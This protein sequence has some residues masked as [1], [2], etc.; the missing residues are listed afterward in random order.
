MLSNDPKIITR[1]TAIKLLAPIMDYD[2][3]QELHALKREEEQEANEA[4]MAAEEGG[5]E[6]E[7]AAASPAENPVTWKTALEAG[8]ITLNEY[9]EKALNLGEIPDGDL[10]MPQYHAKYAQTFVSSVAATSE[11]SV[12][13]ATGKQQATEERDQ[14]SHDM[15]KEMHEETKKDKAASRKAMAEGGPIAGSNRP[16]SASSAQSSGKPGSNP[17]RPN[18]APV[19]PSS[20]SSS[21]AKGS[22]S[23]SE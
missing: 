6:S 23:K 7:E 22:K 16:G 20:G 8:I 3:M 21:P 19:K 13:I 2:A 1:R 17:K 10:T 15:K 12:D 4:A 18:S 14:E 5:A 9:R 11:K